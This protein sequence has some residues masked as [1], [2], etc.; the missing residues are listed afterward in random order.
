LENSKMF[1]VEQFRVGIKVVCFHPC[2]FGDYLS[3]L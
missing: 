2:R 1:H 3:G